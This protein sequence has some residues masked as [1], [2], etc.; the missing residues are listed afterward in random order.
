MRVRCAVVRAVPELASIFGKPA[1]KLSAMCGSL[2]ISQRWLGYIVTVGSFAKVLGY[3]SK[4]DG[5][6]SGVPLGNTRRSLPRNMTTVSLIGH[7]SLGHL[8]LIHRIKK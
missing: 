8:F 5:V 2:L 7:V 3:K 4:A 1:Q 6:G